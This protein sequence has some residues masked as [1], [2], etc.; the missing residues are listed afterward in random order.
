M[1]AVFNRLAAY[2]GK[3]HSFSSVIEVNLVAL[4]KGQTVLEFR[5]AA[6]FSKSDSLDNSFTFG[7]RI[8]EEYLIILAEIKTSPDLVRRK[9]QT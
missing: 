3:N 7:F 9:L 6:F 4:L 1:Y 5:K 8:V 2:N